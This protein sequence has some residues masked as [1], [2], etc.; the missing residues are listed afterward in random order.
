MLAGRSRRDSG[1]VSIR[2][3]ASE[4]LEASN[5]FVIKAFRNVSIRADAS[6]LLE[7]ICPR[8]PGTLLGFN[9]R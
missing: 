3:D 8:V 7:A 9:S 2:A 6:E 1:W 4:L 5:P